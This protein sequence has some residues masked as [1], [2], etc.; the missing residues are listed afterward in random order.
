MRKISFWAKRHPW[1]A[2]II[3][4]VSFV[5]LNVLGFATGLLLADM[6]IILPAALMFLFILLYAAG[7]ISYPVTNKIERGKKRL[8]V[9]AR[10]KTCDILLA[11]STFFIIVF[12]G[13][14]QE[15]L[16]RYSLPFNEVRASSSII[17]KDSTTKNYKSIPAFYQSLKDANGKPY[18]W[19]ER[20]KLLKEQV[21]A[22]KKANDM[23][24][25]EKTALI[26]LSVA[27][28][29]GLIYL[30]G[31]LACNLSCAGSDVAAVIVGVGGTGLVI[32][33]LIVVIR[34]ILGKQRHSKKSA[35]I[36]SAIIQ[37]A[38]AKAEK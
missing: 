33:L 26:I 30:I 28:A 4:V 32:F 25:G 9:F 35:G 14:H 22:I 24:P 27:V 19:K 8:N 36:K 12:L 13:N 21:S 29:L 17:P 23:G 1:P 18:G 20:K 11:G 5:I 31:A 7:Y 37:E 10:Q 2:R 34:K 15:T 38:L 6:D 16:F 3:I